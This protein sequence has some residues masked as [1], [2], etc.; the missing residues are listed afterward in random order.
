MERT[1]KLKV[2]NPREPKSTFKRP[3]GR[4]CNYVHINYVRTR[5][6]LNPVQT[7]D[8][9]LFRVAFELVARGQ[10]AVFLSPKSEE[11]RKKKKEKKNECEM[12]T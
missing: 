7:P 10:S 11:R 4:S 9:S 3:E 5:A 12:L 6:G 8:S 2:T 1:L